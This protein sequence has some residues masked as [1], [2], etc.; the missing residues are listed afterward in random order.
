MIRFLQTKGRIQQVLLV[1]FLSIICIMMV[2]TLIP[3]G[4]T[5]T[6]FLGLG[7]SQN[8]IAKVGG[9]EITSQELTKQAQNM[10]RQQYGP[11]AQMALPFIMPQVANMLITQRLVLNEAKRLGLSATDEDL[12]NYLEHGQFAQLL[13]PDGKFVGQT[14]YEAI[15]SGQF[16]MTKQEFEDTLRKQISMDKLREAIEGGVVATD[17]EL[18]QQFKAE[19]TRVKFDY[20]V[21]SLDDIEKTVTPTDAE[22][23]AFYEKQKPQLANS[24]PE[25]RK[26]KYILVDFAKAAGSVSQSDLESYY[27]QHMN[28]YRVPASVTVRHILIATPPAGPDGKVD[29]KAVDAAKAKAEDVLRQ[30]KA[31]AKFEDLAKKYSEDPGS[32]D[33]GGLIGPIQKGQTVPEFEQAAFS[34]PKGQI[35]GPVKSSF[36]FHI[37][38]V[39][40]KTEA[41]TKSLDEMKA[42]IEPIIARQ[43]GQ[44]AA[45]SLAKTLQA[46]AATQG[47]EKAA[48]SRGLQ[49]MDSN[50][51]SR[52]TPLPGV[53]ISSSFTD[54][55]FSAPKA[56]STPQAV[57]V[58]NGWAVVQV[59]DIKPPA[60]PTFEEAKARLSEEL[61]QQ[62]ASAE[63]ESKIKE[64]SD[65][66]HA[67][68]NL[69][70]AAKAV[71]ATVKTSELVKPGDQVP[72]VGQLAGPAEVVFS[73]KPGDISAPV[74][75]GSS[76]VVFALTDKQEPPASEF[77]Q[78]KDQL[79]Q[80]ILQRKRSEALQLYIG[81][82]RDKMQKDGKIRINEKEI[83]RLTSATSGS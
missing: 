74:P 17:A 41:H 70:A 59:T 35:V 56:P 15:V 14:Q 37:I 3:G 42:Q 63:L 65:K 1:G 47:M 82:L 26:I 39:D 73:M 8:V 10:A 36:G 9:E 81:S 45:E 18:Q 32:K 54:A 53:G 80:S 76:G 4:S 83:Q 34:A 33:K 13:F 64:L 20:A 52:G 57:A 58:Q 55:V 62:K 6:D 68:H 40:D 51:F 75:L 43:K 30:L 28:E 79:R 71:G 7:L 50:F 77:D 31:G 27:K 69:R 60:T 21:L 61:K 11:R 16:N 67:E 5:L 72:Q 48:A 24:I 46:A 44:A 78:Q 23:R 29:Q 25:Q 12:R 22:L 66:A 38:R 2:V 49:V 19:N